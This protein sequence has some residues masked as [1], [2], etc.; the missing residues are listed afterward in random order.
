LIRP[1]RSA[2]FADCIFA[3][4]FNASLDSGYRECVPCQENINV[5]AFHNSRCLDFLHGQITLGGP[6]I[7]IQS[8]YL[9]WVMPLT[10]GLPGLLAVHHHRCFVLRSQVALTAYEDASVLFR[11][12]E[13][14]FFHVP[15]DLGEITFHDFRHN[16]S[17]IFDRRTSLYQ[18]VLS[19][20]VPKVSTPTSTPGLMNFSL[21]ALLNATNGTALAAARSALRTSSPH[22][23]SCSPTASPTGARIGGGCPGSP[24]SRA[25]AHVR[26]VR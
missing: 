19:T 2:L 10:D 1:A 24:G 26:D 7:F 9:S 3:E 12:S 22:T 8:A 25:A 17:R 15:A 5:A 13:E 23:L 21:I 11:L 14:P 6:D 4:T 16:I 20:A 18:F